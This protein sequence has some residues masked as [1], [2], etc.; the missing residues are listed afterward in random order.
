M[1]NGDLNKSYVTLAEILDIA[2]VILKPNHEP[3]CPGQ[4]MSWSS[5]VTATKASH[6]LELHVGACNYSVCMYTRMYVF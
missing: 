1:P 4:A 2:S 6:D 3:I 5:E